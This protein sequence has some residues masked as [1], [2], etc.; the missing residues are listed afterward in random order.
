MTKRFFISA[1]GTEIGKTFISCAFSSQ[2]VKKQYDIACIKPIISG[3]EDGNEAMD[4]IQILKAVGKE[5][6]AENID[7]ISPWRFKAPL[8]PDMAAELENSE[9]NFDE[10]VSF[11]QKDTPEILLIE[12]AGGAFVPINKERTHADLI[13]A[14]D[15]GVI[16]VSGTYL[17]T[18]SHTIS[19]IKALHAEGIKIHCVILNESKGGVDIDMT[20][21]T[22]ENFT[23]IPIIKSHFVEK[24]DNPWQYADDL[25]QI[26]DLV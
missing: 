19:C 26:L 12:G 6:T 3:W 1:T 23:S 4:T 22:L 5:V 18:I 7:K 9:I 24:K 2:L 10:L 25:T 11:C 21:K 15:I 14:L 13:K 17:G 20:A 16:L 8:S